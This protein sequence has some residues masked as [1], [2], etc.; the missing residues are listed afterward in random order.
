[1]QEESS[2]RWHKLTQYVLEDS[3]R[4][5]LRALCKG[6]EDPID[7]RSRIIALNP[8]LA[9]N[10]CEWIQYDPYYGSWENW[11]NTRTPSDLLWITGKPGS[12]KTMLAL[13]IIQE[14]EKKAEVDTDMTIL[15]YFLNSNDENSLRTLVRGLLRR[16]IA[17][18]KDLLKFLVAHWEIEGDRLFQGENT[19]DDFS[20]TA[21]IWR[22]WR[23]FVRLIEDP[24]AGKVYCI[25]DG[26]D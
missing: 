16:L 5:C 14:L 19:G 20:I 18:R 11:K 21:G 10:I 6:I 22:L 7:T 1:V 12:G 15:Y 26:L 23:I 25:V 4:D 3:R 9:A 8:K 13:Y 2:F 17:V 24:L